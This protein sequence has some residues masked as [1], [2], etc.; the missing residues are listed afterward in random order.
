MAIS[1]FANIAGDRAVLNV[2]RVADDLAKV[3]QRLSSGLQ[4]RTDALAGYVVADQIETT[5]RSLQ[6]ADSNIQAALAALDLSDTALG[7]INDGLGDLIDLAVQ[8]ADGLLTDAQRAPLDA[9][10]QAIVDSFDDLIADTT[11]GGTS[12]LD[13][14]YG[15]VT[16]QVGSTTGA[17][18]TVDFSE[19]FRTTNAGGPLGG[20]NGLSI[21]TQ[22]NASAAIDALTG[23]APAVDLD[24]TAARATLS[25]PYSALELSAK[26][27]STMRIEYDAG[28][29]R[30]VGADVA[31]D[32][33][34]LVRDQ[35]LLDAGASA[36]QASSF[37]ASTIVN[38]L[39]SSV[40]RSN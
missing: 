11:W 25:A 29:I 34:R 1:I 12:L 9:A 20:L 17:T 21:D 26:N 22:A 38:L 30:I 33:I 37:S 24:F 32:A 15:S 31:A 19:D 27:N 13:G 36:L 10:F 14:S 6:G 5:I 3:T 23:A 4:L 35:L 40:G 16:L 7:T 8:A 39:A 18:A 28:R 2:N